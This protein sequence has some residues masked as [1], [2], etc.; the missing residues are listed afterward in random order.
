MELIKHA[1]TTKA[2]TGVTTVA[3]AASTSASYFL[4]TDKGYN[5]ASTTHTLKSGKA[6][7]SGS[8]VLIAITKDPNEYCT[9]VDNA[10][11]NEYY[12]ETNENGVKGRYIVKKLGANVAVAGTY[13]LSKMTCV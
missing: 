10:G 7:T 9:V 11:S 6:L 13:S 3:V 12:M 8:F 5:R 1:F 4:D 2:S